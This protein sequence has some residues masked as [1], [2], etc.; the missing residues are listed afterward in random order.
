MI[1]FYSP[2][3]VATINTTKYII[4]NDLTKKKKRKK[5]TNTWHVN[6]RSPLS[7]YFVVFK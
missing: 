4:E 2:Q 1:S 6:K 5:H 3:I 7:Y